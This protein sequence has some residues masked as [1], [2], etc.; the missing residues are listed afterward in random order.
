VQ[1]TLWDVAAMV[2]SAKIEARRL[3]AEMKTHKIS[4]VRVAWF[5]HKVCDAFADLTDPEKGHLFKTL[6]SF[7]QLRRVLDLE[8]K[9][10]VEAAREA[11]ECL[12]QLRDRLGAFW[13]PIPFC[14][15]GP[16]EDLIRLADEQRRVTEML[17][18]H[19][20]GLQ[21]SRLPRNPD[22]PKTEADFTADE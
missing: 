12:K 8:E 3:L 6:G 10:D 1:D 14:G 21:K 17:Q 19:L 5:Q 16:L 22:Q 9:A 13:E 7:S 2:V 18:S 20:N 4:K 11:R 15:Y